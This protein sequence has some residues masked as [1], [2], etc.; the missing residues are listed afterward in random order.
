MFIGQLVSKDFNP[1][2]TVGLTKIR[3]FLKHKISGS[4]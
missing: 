3:P 1:F 4:A 2:T